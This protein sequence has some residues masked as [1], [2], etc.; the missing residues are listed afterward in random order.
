M[1]IADRHGF[2]FQFT[3]AAVWRG[4]ARVRLGDQ[5]GIEDIEKSLS[6]F[7]SI[8]SAAAGLFIAAS[9]AA[10]AETGRHQEAL[11][12]LAQSP[13]R[14]SDPMSLAELSRLEGELDLGFGDVARAEAC[15]RTA[16]DIARGQEAKSWELKAA[17]SLARLLAGQSK[18]DEARTMLFDVYRWFTEGF[19][20]ADLKE[21]KKLLEELDQT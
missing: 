17:I 7:A 6:T 14:G 5:G 8:G 2:T 12:L 10:Y 13:L 4:C 11:A 15:Y 9:A 1:A 19:D 16:I 20:T 18:K 21:A 3:V